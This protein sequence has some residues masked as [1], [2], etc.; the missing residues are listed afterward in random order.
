MAKMRVHELAKELE[1]KSQDIIDTLSSTEY[2]VKSA[3]SGI[4]DAAQ[5]IVRKKFSKK[6]EQPKEEKKKSEKVDNVPKLGITKGLVLVGDLFPLTFVKGDINAIAEES[7]QF[8]GLQTA[9]APGDLLDMAVGKGHVTAPATLADLVV[10]TNGLAFAVPLRPV[11]LAV[12]RRLGLKRAVAFPFVA[13]LMRRHTVR[14]I[15]RR[16]L[17]QH[18]QAIGLLHMSVAERPAVVCRRRRTRTLRIVIAEAR[19][20]HIAPIRRLV[21]VFIQ[22]ILA[23]L[24]VR[25]TDIRVAAAADITPDDTVR[26]RIGDVI[27]N[28]RAVERTDRHRLMSGRKP[29]AGGVGTIGIALI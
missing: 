24:D 19:V 29:L 10:E 15:H 5:E 7:R 27:V 16:Q 25:R 12:H 11:L 20:H 23:V 17:G 8:L 3:Q 13:V 4:E 18:Q 28:A 22:V 2:A 9:H 26:D 21:T 1:I 6:V 14:R